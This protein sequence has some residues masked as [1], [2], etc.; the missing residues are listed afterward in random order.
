MPTLRDR[1]LAMLD[2]VEHMQLT[3]EEVVTIDLLGGVN[4]LVTLPCLRRIE[5]DGGPPSV[6]GELDGR[7]FHQLSR[8]A[9]TFV[10]V[11]GG[12]A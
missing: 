1:L 9:I 12:E 10:A 8:S 2:T 11:E 5:Q 4:L 7:V 6:R 3:A